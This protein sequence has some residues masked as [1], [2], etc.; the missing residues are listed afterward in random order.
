MLFQLLLLLVFLMLKHFTQ[1]VF[2]MLK[3]FTQLL[4]FQCSVLK[5]TWE[6]QDHTAMCYYSSFFFFPMKSLCETG[7][8][9]IVSYQSEP[10]V[11][12]LY[13]TPCVRLLLQLCLH[14]SH[15]TTHLQSL[16][17]HLTKHCFH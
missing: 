7:F 5:S 10:M 3:H 12:N 2:L 15:H 13:I 17:Y 1:L 9:E 8:S 11:C 14:F 16:H 6:N 4:H